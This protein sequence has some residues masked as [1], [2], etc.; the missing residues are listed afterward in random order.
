MD[1][2]K[3]LQY[4]T[5]QRWSL[6]ATGV[7]H[8]VLIKYYEQEKSHSIFQCDIQSKPRAANTHCI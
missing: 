7:S 3:F 6:E 5:L 2:V 1:G 4:P 8:E